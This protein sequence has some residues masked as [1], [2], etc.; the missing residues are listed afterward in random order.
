[1]AKETLELRGAQAAKLARLVE[2][3]AKAA[4]ALAAAKDRELV[5]RNEI[6]RMCH[7][8]PDAEGAH[9]VLAG[10]WVLTV[11]AKLNRTLDVA[12]L[13]AVMEQMPEEWRVVGKLIDYKPALVLDGYRQLEGRAA[14]VFAAALTVR[15]GTPALK[16]TKAEPK[17][18]R[19]TR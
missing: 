4:D 6:V 1:M 3:H 17:A 15:P 14:S 7:L 18:K 19:S 11:D 5:L 16:Y 2:Q 13:D 9:K 10:K 12:A 8:P